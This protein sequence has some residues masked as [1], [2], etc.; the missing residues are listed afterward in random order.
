MDMTENLEGQK[1]STSCFTYE[2][3]MLV[4]VLAKSKEE[5]DLRLDKEGGY[6][7]KREVS[8]KDM[9]ALYSGERLISEEKE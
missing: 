6:V 5:A 1:E 2:V 8:F 7:S 9:V 3:T 4:Q